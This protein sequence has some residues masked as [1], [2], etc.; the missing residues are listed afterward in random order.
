[1][2]T[3]GQDRTAMLVSWVAPRSSCFASNVAVASVYQNWLAFQSS[4]N[5]D[6]EIGYSMLTLDFMSANRDKAS[7]RPA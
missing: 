1:M 6:M 7:S 3:L 2:K 5:M 4:A